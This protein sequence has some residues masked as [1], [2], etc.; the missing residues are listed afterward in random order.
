[1]DALSGAPS[2]QNPDS[3]PSFFHHGVGLLDPRPAY[4]YYAGQDP[5]KTFNIFLGTTHIPVLDVAPATAAVAAIAASQTPGAAG[6][7]T[8][9]SSTGAGVTVGVSIVRADTGATVTGLLA[10]GGAAGTASIGTGST[11]KVW[12]PTTLLARCV[13]ITSGSDISNRTLTING[14]DIYNFPMTQAITG[15]NNATV[16]TTK[17]F[18]YI[19]TIAISGAAAGAITV[20]TSDTIGLPLRAD[21]WAQITAYMNNVLLTASTGFTAA[22]T[23]SPA[24][25]STGDTRGTYA[26]QTASDGTKRVQIYASPSVANYGTVA[27]LFG[28][29]QV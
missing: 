16:T 15:P 26:L 24:T 27:G 25:T 13:S 7:L 28:V 9:V 18:K 29:T 22:V 1:M 14:Y 23:T 2:G 6:N 21:R 3:G 5:T 19:S 8:L 20:D 12:D 10:I 4:T 17:A 11:V